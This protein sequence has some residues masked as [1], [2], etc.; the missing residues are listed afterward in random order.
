MKNIKLIIFNGCPNL[1]QFVYDYKLYNN[2]HAGE[3][4]AIKGRPTLSYPQTRACW[5]LE[6]HYS[7]FSNR[8]M[9]MAT[10]TQL[11]PCQ[12]SS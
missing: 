7:T 6:K 1:T 4:T 2:Q 10:G 3:T 11:S 5:E 9:K 8:E 12:H